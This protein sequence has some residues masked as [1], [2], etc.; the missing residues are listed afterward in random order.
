V[1]IEHWVHS[2]IDGDALRFDLLSK[3]HHSVRRDGRLHARGWSGQDWWTEEL[4]STAP[5]EKLRAPR[6]MMNIS[7]SAWHRRSGMQYAP[8]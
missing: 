4:A 1:L 7:D 8:R 6:P 5:N 3:L 2:S